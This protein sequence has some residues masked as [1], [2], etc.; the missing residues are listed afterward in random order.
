MNVMIGNERIEV[1]IIRSNRKTWE[2]RITPE[3]AVCVRGPLKVSEKKLLELIQT[4]S[5]W[6]ANK[7]EAILRRQS[8]KPGRSYDEG[9]TYPYQGTEYPLSVI[10]NPWDR[11]VSVDFTTE[12]YLV[13]VPEHDS[14]VVR[15]ALELWCRKQAKLILPKRLRVLEERMGLKSMQI[16][17][18]DQKKRWGS[19]SSRGNVNLNWRLMLMPPEV[20]DSVLI[21]ELAHLVHPNHSMDFYRYLELHN[22][23]YKD[24]E[25]WLKERGRELFY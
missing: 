15:E 22:P 9:E 6:I 24:H 23:R 18:K 2:I 16:T 1:Q 8:L 5:A 20:M 10:R 14:S 4:K 17:I 3:G 12:G 19:C 11:K 13:S 25:R 21:H 7:R